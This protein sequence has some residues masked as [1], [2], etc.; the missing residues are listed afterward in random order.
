[1]TEGFYVRETLNMKTNVERQ[2]GCPGNALCSAD[3]CG[4]VHPLVTDGRNPRSWNRGKDET[5]RDGMSLRR[6]SHRTS[7]GRSLR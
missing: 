2:H 3:P 6:V 7:G 1:M 5:V 4:P